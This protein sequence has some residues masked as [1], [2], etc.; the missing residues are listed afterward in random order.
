MK[1]KLFSIALL[2]AF[3]LSLA[4]GGGRATTAAVSTAPPPP[5]QEDASIGAALQPSS[6]LFRS[7]PQPIS[8]AP[9]V[10][11]GASGLSYRYVQTLGVTGEPYPADG[12]HLNL[13][14]G[15]FVDPGSNLYVVEYRG[16][17]ML[18][19]SSAG[20]NQLIIGHAGLP[21]H[22][23]D[24]LS[25]PAD[26][27]VRSD[28]H[29]WI[30]ITHA[31]KE[32]DAA[33]NLVQIFPDEDPWNPGDDN[34]HFNSPKSL[35]FDAAGR[36]FVSDSGNHRIQ[37]YDLSSGV[38]N[39]VETIGLGVPDNSNLGFDF[40]TGIAFDS[41]GR[42][43]VADFNN[44]RIQ[45]CVYTTAW[46]CTTFFG[47]TGVP[48][49]DL[50]HLQYALGVAVRNN[51]VYIA[52]SDNHRVLKCNLSGICAHFAGVTNVPGSDNFHFNYPI[53]V[54]VDA[55]N[56][57]YVS[58]HVNHRVQKFSSLGVYQGTFGV[59]LTPYVPDAVRIHTPWG[60]AIAPDGGI[61]V[62]ENLGYRLLKY[63][64]SGVQQW[65]V[66][67]A[68]IYGEDHSH[69]G[70]WWAGLEG[71][72]AVDAN[73]R[74]YVTDTG[75]QRVMIFNPDGTFYAQ[76]GETRVPGDDNSH[77]DCPA[78]AAIN[79][80]NGDVFIVD[81]CNQR[82]QVFYSNLTYKATLGVLDEPGSD[83]LHFNDPWDVAVDASGNIYVADSVN[84][85]VQKCNL[86]GPGYTCSTFAGVTGEFSFLF[87]HLFPLGVEVD[88][89]GRVF[90]ADE[91]NSRIQVFDS[92]GAYLTTI[93]GSWGDNNGSLINPRGVAVDRRGRVYI[94]DHYNHRIQVFAPGYPGW[95]QSNLNGFGNPFTESISDMA[96]FE[97]ELY[98][99]ASYGYPDGT[100]GSE[101]WKTADGKNWSRVNQVG[102]NLEM[103]TIQSLE[104]FN[105]MLY[106]GTYTDTGGLVYRSADGINWSPASTPGFGFPDNVEIHQLKSFQG[107]LYAGVLNT[108]AGG[109]IW[110]SPNG[111]TW[112]NVITGNYTSGNTVW[113]SFEEHNGQLYAG[114][115]VGDPRQG[116]LIRTSDGV[117]WQS[118]TLDGFGDSTNAAIH[119]L[120]SFNGYLYASTRN[121]NGAQ[122]WRSASG[123]PGTWQKMVNNGFGEPANTRGFTLVA[124]EEMLFFVITNIWT[125]D[126]VWATRNGSDWFPLTLD[127]WGD[128]NTTWSAYS[129]KAATVFEDLV[130]IGA[131]N[132]ANG[133]KVWTYFMRY[134]LFLPVM[135]R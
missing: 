13:P 1:R 70:D 127:G 128:P 14:Y 72:P 52:D 30:L 15:I 27:A 25:N 35:A 107:Y 3:C 76:L 68:G 105:G 43:Y 5:P 91:W 130:F 29:I 133:A 53:D 7:H 45:R 37:I 113:W 81:K 79:P 82:V 87:D 46:N 10:A 100:F 114:F 36:L 22:H 99:G 71:G 66:G 122:V 23:D 126:Q 16:Q 104:E 98:A 80:T 48:G 26:V 55:S 61:Y 11:L 28:G 119:G 74:V 69:F 44:H 120:A 108:G 116:A 124:G 63:N 32:F 60:V 42:L 9:Q 96:E 50:N 33:G 101:L 135:E 64:Q 92:S 24:F 117:H 110:R 132:N 111:L 38:P 129:D 109:Q 102:M 95:V 97:D 93:G 4:A 39:Y 59:T 103:Q 12:D 47:V 18:K 2:L 89:Y 84:Y 8:T 118:V 115:A 19:F 17:R 56:S 121:S 31:L 62:T 54:S 49:N 58:D 123:D 131:S 67:Q 41:S 94:A 86:V 73:G 125:G 85:R 78:G 77:F 40:P 34:Q 20:L 83:N 21:W 51:D 65:A 106:T 112:T 134:P 88:R 57:V 6:H 75:N 90:V